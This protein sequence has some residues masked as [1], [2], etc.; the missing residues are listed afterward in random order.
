MKLTFWGAARQVTGSMYLLELEDDYRILIDCG[1]DMDRERGKEEELPQAFPGSVFPFDASTLNLVLLTHAH[2]DHSGNIPNLYR[3]GYEGQVLCTSPTIDLTHL[4][5]TDSAALHR[6][7]LQNLSKKKKKKQLPPPNV[8]NEWYIEKQVDA[9]MDSF[10]GIAFNQRFQVKKGLHITFIPAGHLLGAANILIEVNEGGKQR[11]IL[12]SGDIGR[13]NYPL[14][15]DPSPVPQV[16]Y[17]ICESTYGGRNH[18]PNVEVEAELEKAIIETCVEKPGR[19]IIPS[20]SV[21]RTQSLLYTFNKLATQRRLPPI[22]VFSDSPMALQSTKIY[23]RYS[24]M[25]NKDARDFLATHDTLFDFDNLV[26]VEDLKNSKAISNYREPC[27]II[28]SSGMLEGGRIQHHIRHNLSNPYCTILMIGYSA[29]NTLGRQLLDGIPSLRVGDQE[30]PVLAKVKYT[31][32]F[33]GHGDQDDLI[34]FVKQQAPDR[35]KQ[36]FLV[37]GETDSMEAFRTLLSTE[38]YQQVAMPEKGQTFV[39]D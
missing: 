14:L 7:R 15:P 10:V 32:A 5:L 17:L 39:L 26:I 9:A 18:T 6:R 36:L 11:S 19:L 25:L 3:E 24:K 22:K 21:G 1:F 29:E 13:Y 31:D 20:F 38:G 30:I 16:D 35:L 4:L 28:S 12:F 27:I 8:V 23:A 33:S 34:K 2:I 37:H